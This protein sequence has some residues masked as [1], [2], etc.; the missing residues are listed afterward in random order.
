MEIDSGKYI[1][2]R[3]DRCIVTETGDP[4]ARGS[5]LQDLAL[6]EAHSSA[7]DGA[8]TSRSADD[9]TS[10]FTVNFANDDEQAVACLLREPA[11]CSGCPTPA[12]MSGQI[13]DAVMPA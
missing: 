10:R 13:C 8:V 1:D 2:I 4:D 11:A 5:S 9:L 7:G 3:W 6:R 12:R